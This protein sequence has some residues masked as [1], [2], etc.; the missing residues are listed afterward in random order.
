MVLV[1]Q[2]ESGEHESSNLEQQESAAVWILGTDRLH[3]AVG[4]DRSFDGDD[5]V[6][7]TNREEGGGSG[8]RAWSRLVDIAVYPV[9]GG[10]DQV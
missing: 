2:S 8:L 5:V 4:A 9:K 1:P 6:C 7:G 3:G 10:G